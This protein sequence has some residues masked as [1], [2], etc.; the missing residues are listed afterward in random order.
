MPIGAWAQP[1]PEPPLV[2]LPMGARVRLQTTA[3]PGN[4]VKGFLAS[5]DSEIVAVVP[6]DAPP[7]GA[8][9]LRLPSSSIARFE[10]ATGRK[11]HWLIGLAA[12][13]AVGLLVG[14][15]AEV[16]PIAC[17]YDYNYECSRGAAYATYGIGFA[18][19]GAGIG[20]LVKTDQWTPVALGALAPPPPRA[21][22]VAPRLRAVPGGA[23]LG[24]TIGF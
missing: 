21:S 24:V 9:Q 15:T 20:A 12:G 14:A 7:L 8:N 17:E 6:Q 4:W 1:A 23:E 2:T 16:D 18:A 3:A 13:A 10:L 19:M 22:G 11:R 5:A